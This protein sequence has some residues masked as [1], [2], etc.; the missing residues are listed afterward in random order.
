MT[1]MKTVQLHTCGEIKARSSLCNSFFSRRVE[2]SEE[3][4][5]SRRNI[6]AIARAASDNCDAKGND[7]LR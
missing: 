1:I 6:Q 2:Q 3:A 4:S 5:Q 7:P